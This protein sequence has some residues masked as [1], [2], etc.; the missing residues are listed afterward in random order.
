MSLV[1]PIAQAQ[2]KK[3]D[4]EWVS[5][6]N[7]KNL[8]GWNMKFKGH[9]LGDN[10]NDTFRVENGVIKVAYDKYDKFNSKFGHLFYKDKF[11]HYDLRVEYRFLGEQAK[12]GPS[13][14]IRNSGIMFHCQPP[15]SMRKDQEFP[16]SIE[17]QFLGGNGKDARVTGSMC[18]PGT[19]VVI[20]G[21]LVTQHCVNSKS[22]TFH[23][24]QWVTAELQ[25]RGSGKV[26]HL[27]NGDVVMEYEQPQYDPK[28]MDGAALLKAANGKLLIEEGYI[29]L[30]AESH[31]C[32][33]RKVEIRTLKK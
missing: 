6:F 31:P 16:V 20:N 23:G 22:K 7:G 21:K 19:N 14:A 17:F 3:A 8:D 26:K 24:E 12:D 28:D 30:Q 9:E 32:E 15:E 1:A 2:D 25:V 10:Y 18:S 11:S 4:G 13:W 27:I 29:A 33:F 5:L